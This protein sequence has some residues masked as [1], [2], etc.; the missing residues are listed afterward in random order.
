VVQVVTECYVCGVSTR[1]VD[2]LVR[3]LGLGGMSKGQVSELAKELDSLVE[4]FRSRPLDAG[5]YTFVWLDALT[6]RCREDGH[7]V[8]VVTVIATGVNCDGHREIPGGDVFTSEDGAGWSSFLRSLVER[9]LS[10]VKLVISDAHSGL[11]AAI[12]E[13]LPGSAWQRCRAHFMCDVLNKVPKS[14]QDLVARWCVRYSLNRQ[15]R[16]YES[17]TRG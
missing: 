10:R 2:G 17:S 11:K 15:R 12:A 16:R 14:T 7:V 5:P 1:R 13:Q 4:G 8:N 3:T 6:Q 9:G